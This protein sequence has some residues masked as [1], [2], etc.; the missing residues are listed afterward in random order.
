[1]SIALGAV[2]AQVQGDG[3]RVKQEAVVSD[4]ENGSL[5]QE[6]RETS[7]Q[8]PIDGELDLH[9][10]H[11]RDVKELIPHYLELCLQNGL[12]EVRIVHGKG[13]GSLRETVHALLRK[14]PYVR[15]FSLAP[16]HRGHWGATLVFLEEPSENDAH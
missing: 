9:A 2:L 8:L 16:A 15:D 7:V 6:C 12:L 13:T 3:S 14:L 1:M 11:P 4:V 5:K 10:F